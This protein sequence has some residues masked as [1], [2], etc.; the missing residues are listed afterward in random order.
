VP[1]SNRKVIFVRQLTGPDATRAMIR[2]S[3]R[4]LSDAGSPNEGTVLFFFGGHG[5]TYKG[6]NYLATFGVTADDLDG[7]G[8]G[9]V[10][11]A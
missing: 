6:S 1:R 2:R 10:K 9:L 11:L 7:E 8:L 5:F 4:E 3:L